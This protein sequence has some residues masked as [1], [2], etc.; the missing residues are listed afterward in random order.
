MSTNLEVSHT[1]LSNYSLE[2]DRSALSFTDG[3]CTVRH[4]TANKNSVP[5]RGSVRNTRR[6]TTVTN[7]LANR[8]DYKSLAS[9]LGG[10]DTCSGRCYV[11]AHHRM[12]E[13]VALSSGVP[14]VILQLHDLNPDDE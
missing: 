2:T 9:H 8:D 12:R 7:W 4:G 1:Q 10:L 5:V 11:L 6:T 14:A 13:A 3:G